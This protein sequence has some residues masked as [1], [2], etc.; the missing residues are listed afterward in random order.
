MLRAVRREIV[1]AD[2]VSSTGVV[3]LSGL[4]VSTSAVDDEGEIVAGLGEDDAHD[5][6]PEMTIAPLLMALSTQSVTRAVNSASEYSGTVA[7]MA[8]F[9][10]A[11]AASRLGSIET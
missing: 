9:I 6:P 3:R 2:A 1:P 4:G 10:L 8:A 11:S 5:A 7:R